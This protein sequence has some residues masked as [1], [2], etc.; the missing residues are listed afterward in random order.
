M[1]SRIMHLAI[2]E[3]INKKYQL[4][5]AFLMGS[6]A[7]DVNKNER[8]PKELTHFMEKRADGEHDM[9][10]DRFLEEY[11]NTLDAFKSGYYLHLISDEYWLK[12]VYRILIVDSMQDRDEILP[13]YYDDF[14]FYNSF[15]IN[16]FNL[17]SI[18]ASAD[19][20]TGVKEISDR[21][22]A[23][24]VNDLDSDF[25]DKTTMTEPN[26]IAPEMILNYINTCVAIFDRAVSGGKIILSN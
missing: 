13:L 26:I 25:A 15:L 23:D 12:N 10:P 18:K 17:T 24:I 6:I 2:G 5:D 20:H 4:G 14:S 1:G 21:A 19:I 22:L 9:F 3:I 11:S 8:T 7:P 16:K